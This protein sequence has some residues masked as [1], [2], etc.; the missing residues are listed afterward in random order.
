MKKKEKAPPQV[1][2]TDKRFNWDLVAKVAAVII[3]A[4]TLG[5]GIYQF[6]VKPRQ[7]ARAKTY[8]SKRELYN[9]AMDSTSRFAIATT[10]AEADVARKQFW[11]LYNGRL[12]VVENQEVKVA[13]QAFGGGVKSWEEFNDPSDFTR[14]ADYEY[15]PNG[16]DKNRVTFA[17]MSYGLT[18]A[19]KRDLEIR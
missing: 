5:F 9:Q 19:C 1:E 18:Q 7:E 4:A 16:Q 15:F 12:S 10:Q 6:V 2:P 13:M 8:E 3:S 17:Q 14:P 11:E